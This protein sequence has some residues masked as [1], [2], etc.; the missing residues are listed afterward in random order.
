MEA[1]KGSFFVLGFFGACTFFLFAIA[2]GT[3]GYGV[4]AM[5][6]GFCSIPCAFLSWLMVK[7]N[8]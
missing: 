1:V 4:E 5:V 8:T 7:L 3:Q 2:L 6:S